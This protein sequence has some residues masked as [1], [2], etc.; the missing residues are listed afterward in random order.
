MKNVGKEYQNYTYLS[1]I[2]I[3]Y[4]LNIK[5]LKNTKMSMKIQYVAI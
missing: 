2:I 1:K 3:I 4:P 5:K